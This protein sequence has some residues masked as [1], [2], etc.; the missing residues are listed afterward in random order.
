MFSQVFQRNRN[1][2]SSSWSVTC[3]KSCS[4]ANSRAVVNFCLATQFFRCK[5]SSSLET[6][7]FTVNCLTLKKKRSNRTQ[8]TKNHPNFWNRL[9]CFNGVWVFGKA[10][11]FS[12]YQCV[13]HRY[14]LFSGLKPFA[15][16]GLGVDTW[17]REFKL[18]DAGSS[19]RN[20]ACLTDPNYDF[21][22][23]IKSSIW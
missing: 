6:E 21:S 2:S 15:S 11:F 13:W 9:P 18:K 10:S 1:R 3:H 8:D 17:G 22:I 5:S 23:H 16:G 7:P 20:K 4:S 14:R 12:Q 19:F